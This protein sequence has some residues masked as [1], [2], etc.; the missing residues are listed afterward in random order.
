MYFRTEHKYHVDGQRSD[1]EA[2]SVLLLQILNVDRVT[3]FHY[4]Q[5]GTRDLSIKIKEVDERIIRFPQ[6]RAAKVALF[7]TWGFGSRN[8][9]FV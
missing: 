4:L 3:T 6:R 1:C 2:T 7:I 8:L 5:E 9:F